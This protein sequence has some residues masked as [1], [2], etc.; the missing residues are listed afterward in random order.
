MKVKILWQVLLVLLEEMKHQYQQSAVYHPINTDSVIDYYFLKDRKAEKEYSNSTIGWALQQAFPEMNIAEKS[1]YNYLYIPATKQRDQ[2][3]FLEKRYPDVFFRYI[4]LQGIGEFLNWCEK[5][6]KLTPAILTE[7]RN[8]INQLKEQKHRHFFCYF[9]IGEQ[10]ARGLA[11]FKNWKTLQLKYLD[12]NQQIVHLSGKIE[13]RRKQFCIVLYKDQKIDLKQDRSVFFLSF[14]RASAD[15]QQPF[16]SAGTYAGV[17]EKGQATAGEIIMESIS[18]D[19]YLATAPNFANDKYPHLLKQNL[20]ITHPSQKTFLNPTPLNHQQ[21]QLEK[22]AGIYKGYICVLKENQPTIIEAISIFRPNGTA[23]C[24]GYSNIYYSGHIELISGGAYAKLSTATADGAHQF[25][26]LL[27]LNYKQSDISHIK[28]SYV[29]SYKNK[30]VSGKEYFKR[31]SKYTK[32]EESI[33]NDDLNECSF[34]EFKDKDFAIRLK[35]FFQN[36]NRLRLFDKLRQPAISET[37]KKRIAGNFIMFF[38]SSSKN[39]RQYA[40]K[41]EPKQNKVWI[42]TKNRIIEGSYY[43]VNHF[44]FIRAESIKNTSEYL[45]QFI[46]Y[47]GEDHSKNILNSMEG[48]AAG[49]SDDDQIQR[50]VSLRFRLI[51]SHTNFEALPSKQIELGS[52]AFDA[53][54]KEYENL[55]YYFAGPYDN[56]LETQAQINFHQNSNLKK[57]TPFNS[58]KANYATA[59]FKAACFT[60]IEL[61]QYLTDYQD[62][63]LNTVNQLAA[64]FTKQITEALNHGFGHRENNIQLLNDQ[65]QQSLSRFSQAFNIKNGWIHFDLIQF[66]RALPPEIT[67]YHLQHL[68]IAV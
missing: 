68:K 35:D 66:Y 48:I 57:T 26:Y 63:N 60:A 44:L 23:Y 61:N 43:F 54:N 49:L 27:E 62:Q 13:I 5:E 9:P 21:K 45:I 56:F 31:I 10:I 55:A 2:F 53:L 11:I 42:K 24:K 20:L 28:G 3:F 33:I 34:D 29:G 41:M 39:I 30:L 65:K 14:A 15:G 22:L 17:D 67:L 59:M 18:E 25:T 37:N 51:R 7:Q 16:K 52:P 64:E 47:I 40:L 36:T 38:H 12:K 8:L 6:N 32:E 50:P 19:T 1:I 58:S 46:I 4:G